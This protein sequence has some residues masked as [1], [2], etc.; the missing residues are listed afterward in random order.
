MGISGD[1]DNVVQSTGLPAVLFLISGALI[2][3]IGLIS[4]LSLFPLVGLDPWDHKALFILPAAIYLI[5]VFSFLAAHLFVPGSPF[6]LEYFMGREIMV[7]ANPFIFLFFLIFGVVLPVLYVTL[8]HKLFPRLPAWLRNETV[9]L[10]W[11]DL[12]LPGIL[13]AV[14]VVIGLV[15][16]ILEGIC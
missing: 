7:A 1:F 2:L 3:C 16:V 4:L 9:K 11:K 15:I 5:S 12:R 13:W 10:T 6:D 8:F 14:S